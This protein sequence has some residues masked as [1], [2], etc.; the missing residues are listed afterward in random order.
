MI[1]GAL[2]YLD[3]QIHGQNLSEANIFVI[4]PIQLQS[5]KFRFKILN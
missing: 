2:E 3:T 1:Y 4:N 5:Q